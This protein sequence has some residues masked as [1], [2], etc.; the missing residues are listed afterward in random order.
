MPFDLPIIDGANG[1][2]S[3]VAPGR[4]VGLLYGYKGFGVF[5]TDAE[6]AASGLMTD[7][8]A[9]YKAG[10]FHFEDFK[11]DG[12]INEADKQVIGDPNPDFFGGISTSLTYKNFDLDAIF[13]Y[14]YGNDVM[15]VLRSKLETGAGYENQTVAVLS[16]WMTSGDQTIVPNTQYGDPAG[17]SRPSAFYIED[18]SYFKLRSL[19][20]SY[21]I[22]KRISFA[23]SAQFYLSGYNLFTVSKYL[24]WDPEV[25]IGQNAFTRGYDF[26][27]YPLS[28]M[29]MLGL[30][31]G[32]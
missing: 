4:P 8:G 27:N 6:A 21:S 28:R 25:A 13:S 22:K 12:I 32:L 31:I 20:L 1:Y 10:D 23:R 17:N 24:G 5:S 19:T 15:N 30:R 2:T 26:G 16:R 3:I 11:A 18:G 9:P 29:F 7:K 14:A